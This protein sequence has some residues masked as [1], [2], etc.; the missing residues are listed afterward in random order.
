MNGAKAPLRGDRDVCLGRDL[1]PDVR[2]QRLRS[3]RPSLRKPGLAVAISEMR[4]RRSVAERLRRGPVAGCEMRKKEVKTSW[5]Q[6]PM[7]IPS[8]SCS[9]AWSTWACSSRS[10]A[11][12][13]NTA[14]RLPTL[15][16]LTTK[17]PTRRLRP[18]AGGRRTVGGG[19]AARNEGCAVN[20]LRSGSES[21]FEAAFQQASPIISSTMR[22]ND[23]AQSSMF[24]Y[25]S[26]DARVPAN[27][28][29][30]PVRIMVDQAMA[31]MTGE[32]AR[33]CANVGRPS[34]PPERH[35]QPR[36]DCRVL[37]KSNY[38]TRTRW[39]LSPTPLPVPL[40]FIWAPEVL[41][42]SFVALRICRP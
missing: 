8:T 17:F 6:W 37:L 12:Q 34:I 35:W 40:Q 21:A 14:F 15:A 33:V 27:H 28:P 16:S 38:E 22:G 11:R 4:K 41:H 1:E 26:P 10:G 13:P 23:L 24:C 20:P 31:E 32:F 18:S 2:G 7:P 25:V 42:D 36:Q 3:R 39:T 9:A 19:L 29:L 5:R 30:R